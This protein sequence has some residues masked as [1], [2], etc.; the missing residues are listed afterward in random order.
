M[1]PFLCDVIIEVCGINVPHCALCEERLTNVLEGPLWRRACRHA[2]TQRLIR[3]AQHA[4]MW[5][6]IEVR[7][8]ETEKET[9]VKS[10]DVSISILWDMGS[11][12]A[13]MGRTPPAV[14]ATK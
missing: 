6:E 3:R 11:G 4:C 14:R 13:I 9:V 8:N 2:D 12:N 5:R 10:G 7:E 1:R